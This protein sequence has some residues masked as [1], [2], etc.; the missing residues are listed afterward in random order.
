MFAYN[1]CIFSSVTNSVDNI[2]NLKYYLPYIISLMKWEGGRTPP[3]H[4]TLTELAI[5]YTYL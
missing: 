2:I 3:W 1:N 5:R 4:E